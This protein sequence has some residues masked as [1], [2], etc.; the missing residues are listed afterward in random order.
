MIVVTLVKQVV[1]VQCHL[2][3]GL[4]KRQFL[5]YGEV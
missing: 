4:A 2:Q 3:L 1:G 5:A